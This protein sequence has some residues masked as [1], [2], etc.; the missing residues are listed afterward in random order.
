MVLPPLAVVLLHFWLTWTTL[1]PAAYCNMPLL[2][3]PLAEQR[4][5]AAVGLLDA[6]AV[7]LGAVQPLA[8]Q[9][10]SSGPVAPAALCAATVTWLHVTVMFVLP[11]LFNVWMWQ[12]HMQETEAAGAAAPCGTLRRLLVV[13][14]GAAD[15][16]MHRLLGGAARSPLTRAAVAYYI[17]ANAW[18]LCSI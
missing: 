18:L 9:L 13:A 14:C 8:A 12:P 7:P 11:V 16:G 3:G 2:M 5:S 4:H 10:A 15:R 17:L 1:N 6:A